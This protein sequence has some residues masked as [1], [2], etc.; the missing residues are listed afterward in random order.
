MGS[1]P[2]GGRRALE[3]EPDDGLAARP[4][5]RVARLQGRQPDQGRHGRRRALPQTH[6]S[7]LWGPRPG[8]LNM[9]PR[10]AP[11]NLRLEPGEAK[12]RKQLDLERRGGSAALT[13]SLDTYGSLPREPREN[14][15]RSSH[16]E[17]RT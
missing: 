11:K 9:T 15:T 5:R 4:L 1:R 6:G 10:Y 12:A 14:R 8:E 16:A 13:A 17:F 2:Q 7:R 3:R